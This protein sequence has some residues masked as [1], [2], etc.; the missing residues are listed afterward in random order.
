M[1]W[2]KEW[3]TE[4]GSYWFYGYFNYGVGREG[5]HFVE[6]YRHAGSLTVM[7]GTTTAYCGNTLIQPE[8]AFGVWQKAEVPE[9]PSYKDA[10]CER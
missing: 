9:L 1:N 8:L 6:V 7:A 10:F 2:T 3:P 5:L 4:P